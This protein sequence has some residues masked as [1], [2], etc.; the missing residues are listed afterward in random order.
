MA[1]RSY[2]LYLRNYVG[3][4]DFDSDYA[5]YVLTANADKPV[6]VLID[7]RGGQ[8]STALSIAAAFRDHGD[9]SVHFT[10]FN[11][12]AATVASLGAKHITMARDAFYLVHQA[13]RPFFEFSS[14]NA[15]QIEQKCKDLEKQKAELVKFD[16]TISESYALRCR[17]KPEDLLALMKKETWLTAA[18][19]LEWGFIDEITDYPDDSAADLTD[20]IAAEFTA[21]GISIP[22]SLKKKSPITRLFDRITSLISNHEMNKPD[23]RSDRDILLAIEARQ[24]DFERRISSIEAKSP[25]TQQPQDKQPED[26]QPE[27]KQPEAKESPITSEATQIVNGS[28]AAPEDKDTFAATCK[29]AAA[30]F[31]SLP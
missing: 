26:K 29:S 24:Y 31:N 15:D 10:G 8:L 27:D 22:Q 12:S 30:L 18:E 23:P 19:A 20:D 5:L 16:K 21:A 28:S 7:S 3:G 11:A 14:L 2:T 9:V 13:S 1:K 6:S 25:S 4:W 17:K